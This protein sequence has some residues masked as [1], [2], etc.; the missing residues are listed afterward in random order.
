MRILITG[1][2][3]FIGQNLF[4]YF[5]SKHDII[6]FEWGES[7]LEVK[8]Y[9]WVIHLGAISSTT[10][11]D[12]K[13]LYKQNLKFTIDLY[14]ECVKHHVN[15]QFASSASVYGKNSSFEESAVLNPL[16]PYAW[17][18]YL[19]EQYILNTLSKNN[20]VQIF[21]Y[22]NVYGPYE[23]HKNDQASPYTKFT[24]QAETTG[25]IKLFKNSE[26]Y[27]RDFIHVNKVIE[28][29]ELFLDINKSNIWNIGSGKTT[30]FY[31]IAKEIQ[32]KYNCEIKL[33]DM[34]KKLQDSYQSYTKAN[35]T[36][37]NRTI[38]EKILDK[39]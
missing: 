18:K 1:Y 33:I 14:N 38:D 12:L 24:I 21:R 37:L 17:S 31:S 11:T 16:T 27:Y 28:Y 23:T 32:E 26:N 9:D 35:L 19:A 39:I 3:G 5:E 34:P 30:S 13:K 4:K 6:G 15:M 29:H 20:I 7:S 36:K 2:K 25:V 8:N 22:F 10:E